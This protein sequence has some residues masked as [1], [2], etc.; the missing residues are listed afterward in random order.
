[1]MII[2]LPH[3]GNNFVTFFFFGRKKKMCRSVP[4]PPLGLSTFQLKN[5]KNLTEQ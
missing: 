2:P 3:Y 4:P 1:M 5:F